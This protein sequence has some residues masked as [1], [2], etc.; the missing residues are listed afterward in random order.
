[1]KTLLAGAAALA[2][3]TPALA[4]A[5]TVDG[6]WKAVLDSAKT[7]KKPEIYVIKD[8]V[9]ECQTCTPAYSVKADGMD[10][11]VKGI[12]YFDSASV[13]LSDHGLVEIDKKGG[14]TVTTSTITVSADGKTA[15]IDFTDSSASTT[16]VTGKVIL[17]RVG[18][19]SAGM[20]P[21]SGSWRTASYSSLS[22]N[23]ITI[24]Y[25]TSGD[26]LTMSTP[27]GQG[28]AAKLGG[29]AVPYKGDPGTDMVSVKM[30]GTSLVE[31]DMRAG[32][33]I[34]VITTA[35]SADGQSVAVAYENKLKGTTMRFTA[36]KM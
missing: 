14:K 9:Y 2:L 30:S 36:K 22:D 10:H 7:P 8:G 23:G 32:K 17:A 33:V 26:M 29:P 13:K 34:G 3:L 16:P 27:A 5:Q 25:K 19:A 1:M 35:P 12:P 6:T 28:Y 24:T 15:T 11:P 18:A 21:F 20:N 4:M 31:T